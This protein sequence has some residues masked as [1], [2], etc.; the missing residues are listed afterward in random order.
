M[1]F[2][3]CLSLLVSFPIHNFLVSSPGLF[4]SAERCYLS[5]CCKAGVVLLNSLSLCL[6]FDFSVESERRYLLGRLFLVV[7]F[8]LSSL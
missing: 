1:I 7:G 4:V 8:S 3:I 5:L 2:I 6:Y